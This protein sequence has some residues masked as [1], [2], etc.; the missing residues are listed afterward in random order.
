MAY[1]PSVQERK[2]DFCFLVRSILP[3]SMADAV[4]DHDI[5]EAL[6][7][8]LWGIP[9]ERVAYDRLGPLADIIAVRLRV[10]LG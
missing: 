2:A 7:E 9:L 5:D 3:R 1:V 10:R 8:A 4:T 6:D